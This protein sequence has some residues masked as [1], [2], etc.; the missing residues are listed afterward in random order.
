MRKRIQRYFDRR[1]ILKAVGSFDEAG[2]LFAVE[3]GQKEALQTLLES[4]ISPDTRD[5]EGRP[6]I[7]LAVLRKQPLSLQTLLQHSVELNVIDAKGR[8]PLLLAIL[9][10]DKHSFHELL[11]AGADPNLA[12][13]DGNTPLITAAQNATAIYVRELLEAGAEPNA[14][15]HIGKTALMIAADHQRTACIK[16]LL[17][18]GADPHLRDAEGK[19]ALDQAELSPRAKEL[20]REASQQQA[21]SQLPPINDKLAALF[22]GLLEGSLKTLNESD[23][24]VALE[25]KGVE[26]ITRLTSDEQLATWLG[27]LEETKIQAEIK[28]WLDLIVE[29]R[30]I[31]ALQQK[32]LGT[33]VWAET[34]A[35]RNWQKQLLWLAQDYRAYLESKE[36]K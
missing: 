26:L 11:E 34:E 31:L 16:A 24:L 19:S 5:Q 33:D 17:D 20:L 12:D 6:A 13:K 1:S 28:V 10:E 27:K 8:T 18:A 30:E 35:P 2:L 15:N 22:G 29:I 23:D 25:Q 21:K 7:Y 9:Q 14:S 4:G 36:L 3:Q 32:V